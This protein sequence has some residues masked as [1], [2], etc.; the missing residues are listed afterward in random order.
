MSIIKFK[1]LSPLNLKFKELLLIIII[2]IKLFI[3]SCDKNEFKNPF[4]PTINLNSPQNFTA[5]QRGEWILLTWDKNDQIKSGYEIERKEKNE[6]FQFIVTIEN[7]QQISYLDTSIHTDVQYVYRIRGISGENKSDYSQAIS[8][9]AIFPVPYN[10]SVVAMSETSLLLSWKDSCNFEKGFEIE[11]KEIGQNQWQIIDSVSFNIT[12]FLDDSLIYAKEYDYR[13]RAFT[14]KNISEYSSELTSITTLVP[15]T[16]LSAQSSTDSR[17]LLKW[18]DNSMYEY[19]FIIDRRENE[20]NW[21]VLTILPSNIIQFTDTALSIKNTY[22]YRIKAYSQNHQSS[23]SNIVSHRTSFLAPGNLQITHISDTELKLN[24]E[25]NCE[26][27]NGFKIEQKQGESNWLIIA[28]LPENSTQFTLTDLDTSFAY[29]IKIYA[30][31][32]WNISEALE[33]SINYNHCSRYELHNELFQPGG[34]N[35]IV[36]SPSGYLMASGSPPHWGAAITSSANIK[37]WNTYT[38]ELRYSIL[39]DE[40]LSA[41]WSANSLCYSSFGDIL[42]CGTSRKS[43]NVIFWETGGYTKIKALTSHKNGIMSIAFSQEDRFFASASLDSTIKIWNPTD[44][45]HVKTLS[46]HDHAVCSIAFSPN[47]QYLASGGAD[48]RIIIW[49]TVDWSSCRILTENSGPVYSVSF[50]PNGNL[51]ASGSADNSVRIWNTLNWNL[52]TTLIGHLWSVYTVAF[53]PNGNFLASGCRDGTVKLWSTKDWLNKQTFER[54]QDYVNSVVFSPNSKFFVSGGYSDI[55]PDI[56]IYIAKG[57]W[58][59]IN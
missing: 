29:Q 21:N 41:S 25:Y 24:W 54:N 44:W 42:L 23:Y 7:V 30:Y 58:E 50:S 52:L 27:E 31:T 26:F 20:S 34:S 32:T 13:I 59:L 53:S 14:E 3:V 40:L 47:G 12:S 16:N 43:E 56:V 5:I 18:E 57:S 10:L 39:D 45:S 19:G 48:N 9:A 37:I 17:I 22:S 55:N 36:F 49:Q 6:D 28:E 1:I 38:W 4:D 46:N 11:R 33:C 51:L 2:I 15:P 8:I 35:T